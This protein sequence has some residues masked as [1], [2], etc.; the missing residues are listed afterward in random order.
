MF[1]LMLYNQ[2]L[3]KKN[4]KQQS[5]GSK[6]QCGKGV[7]VTWAAKCLG[8]WLSPSP[9]AFSSSSGSSSPGGGVAL[10]IGNTTCRIGAK[11]FCF[12]T[13]L[14]MRKQLRRIM[15]YFHRVW[16][17]KK[18]KRIFLNDVTLASI[19]NIRVWKGTLLLN[20]MRRAIQD[21]V[22]TRRELLSDTSA[23]TLTKKKK[24][25]HTY[26]HTHIH[27]QP[28][29]SLIQMIGLCIFSSSC[30]VDLKLITGTLESRQEHTQDGTTFHCKASDIH[31]LIHT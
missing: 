26:V 9:S 21:R 14:K 18:K 29:W 5:K 7:R 2:N 11:S 30:S 16:F 10:K 3:Q 8:L 6:Y 20:L 19:N 23:L 27:I 17:K 4:N 12:N 31:T 28:N 25:K 22:L 1:F 13:A 15:R 24:K